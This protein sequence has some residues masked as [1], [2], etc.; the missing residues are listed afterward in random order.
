MKGLSV[1]FDSQF[2]NGWR[3]DM[4]IMLIATW[5]GADYQIYTDIG[6]SERI[7]K[8]KI[9]DIKDFDIEEIGFFVGHN[10]HGDFH[11]HGFDI[12]KAV[13]KASAGPL[14]NEGKRFHLFDL[15]RWNK[16]QSLPV[17]MM[18]GFI[19]R[20]MAWRKGQHIK[21]ARWAMSDARLCYDLFNQVRKMER[22]KFLDVKTGKTPFVEVDWV[23]GDKTGEEE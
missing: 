22:V 16:C 4:D 10:L 19:Q 2:E 21:V 12:L 11:T 8:C 18:N 1:L 7:L 9:H 5:D 3:S 15:A 13:K 23:I 17:Q 14:Q 6:L 20:H